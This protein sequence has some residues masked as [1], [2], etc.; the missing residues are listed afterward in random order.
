MKYAMTSLLTLLLSCLSISAR[1]YY[2]TPYSFSQPDG[3]SVSVRLYGN[4]LFINA[5]SEDGYTL[6]QDPEDGYICY[7]LISPDSSEYAS[8]GIRYRGGDAP[9]AVTMIATPHL[10][11]S[12]ESIAK[13]VAE[14]KELLGVKDNETEPKLRSA[15]IMPDTIYGVTV[16][17]D[18]PDCKFTYSVSE[19][20]QFLNGDGESINGNARS[21]KDYFRW[22]SNGRLT[23]IN[24]L[25]KQPY[26]APNVKSYYAPSDATSYTFNL[27]KPVVNDALNSFSKSKDGFD[28]TDLSVNKSCY[29]AVNILYAGSCPNK[30]ATGL[31][32]H[33]G[34]MNITVNND[35]RV[36]RTVSQPYQL[37]YC[38][39]EL[40]MGSFVHESFHL[41][42]GAPDFYTFDNHT[43]NTAEPYNVADEFYLGSKKNPPIPNPWIMDDAGWLDDKIVLNNLKSGTKVNLAYGPG[44][45][46]VYYGNVDGDPM[47]ERYYIEV[48]SFYYYKRT[49]V[50]TPGIYIWHVYEPGD[51]RYSQYQDKLDSRPAASINPFW[52]SY[53][54]R[55][56]SD[57]SEPSAKWN[58]GQ[59]S[60]LYLCD[61][62][63]AGLEMSF[64]YGECDSNAGEVNSIGYNKQ[65]GDQGGSQGG[66]QGGG[67][68]Y[69]KL[70]LTNK[71]SLPSGK[72]GEKYYAKLNPV[73]GDGNYS[74]K[75]KDGLPD[76]LSLNDNFEI[77]GIPTSEVKK[78]L[79]M[80]VCDG[81]G[82]KTEVWLSLK[83]TGE[84]S[85]V[86]D[87]L[88]EN[89][90]VSLIYLNDA[91]A[92]ASTQDNIKCDVY[93]MNGIKID[94]FIL[95][96]GG[97]RIFGNNYPDGVYIVDVNGKRYKI[98]K[99]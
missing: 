66:D 31:W 42:L 61:F 67:T 27:L 5:E 37:T 70:G 7:A 32:S 36:G 77:V 95:D 23:Y 21:I 22:I 68:V 1:C 85:S 4:D 51:N 20:D 98:M 84:N 33:Q 13:K 44:N 86:D 45:A 46:A 53:S 14:S 83:I 89:N 55:V 63:K 8:T 80:L 2:G 69:D 11:I 41:I 72:V 10:R 48:R 30:W 47:K 82:A 28:L 6:I 18:F 92:I 91:F 29:Y 17:I 88:A 52:S 40:S 35:S 57:D 73:G 15:K 78:M 71:D 38:D 87:A 64:C 60:G 75:W 43:G 19:L 93:S 90:A 39:A 58:N 9:K 59:N 94:E 24:L 79:K 26:T 99:Y 54:S 3:D 74:I 12:S 76:G 65:G 50:S 81:T 97:L 96:N 49:A 25:P 62:S 56:F 34:T 16:L